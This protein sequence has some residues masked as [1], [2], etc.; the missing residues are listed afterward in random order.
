[1]HQGMGLEA[2]GANM[3]C[4]P[5]P[6]RWHVVLSRPPLWDYLEIGVEWF[7]LAVQAALALA[8]FITPAN[9]V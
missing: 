5:A 2:C 3:A 9:S 7:G 4:L 1:M 8:S 6:Q